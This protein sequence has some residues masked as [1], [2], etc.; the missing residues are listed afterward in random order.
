M[1]EI[2]KEEMFGN[3]KDFLKSKGIELQ[4]G[5]YSEGIRKG[6]DLLTDTVNLSQKAFDRAK[7][8]MDKGLDQVR[9]TIHEHTAPR[10]E[11]SHAKTAAAGGKQD[12]S[13]SARAGRATAGKASG[14]R[15][16]KSGK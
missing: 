8:A 11:A 13:N 3:L 9:Q 12:A 10:A 7:D 5:S 1:K 15:G 16:K 4:E 6:C 2:N 14:K